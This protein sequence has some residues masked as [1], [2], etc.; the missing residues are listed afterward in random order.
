MRAGGQDGVLGELL[1]LA[2][3]SRELR[4]MGVWIRQGILA[5]MLERFYLGVKSRQSPY[6]VT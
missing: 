5:A 3:G 1:S 6:V 2:L 4:N